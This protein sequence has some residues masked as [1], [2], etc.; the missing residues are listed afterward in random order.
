MHRPGSVHY[1]VIR[2]RM[3]LKAQLLPVLQGIGPEHGMPP[4][5]GMRWGWNEG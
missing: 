3:L 1:L 2:S 4:A 5:E